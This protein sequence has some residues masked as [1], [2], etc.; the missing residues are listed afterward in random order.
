[1]KSEKKGEKIPWIR[2][3]WKEEVLAAVTERE[4][5]K[6]ERRRRRREWCGVKH[7][8][9]GLQFWVKFVCF[10]LFLLRFLRSLFWF[11]SETQREKRE[12]RERESVVWDAKKLWFEVT[13]FR[14]GGDEI[15]FCISRLR[16][17]TLD[18]YTCRPFCMLC[19]AFVCRLRFNRVT[20]TPLRFVP[21][22]HFWCQITVFST[23]HLSWDIL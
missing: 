2:K 5:K 15:I 3:E 13:L 17:Q 20:K 6:I 7:G 9:L 1:M 19:L 18:I 14:D 12:E 16:K 11:C 4:K 21:F 22:F 8:I 23:S 10:F